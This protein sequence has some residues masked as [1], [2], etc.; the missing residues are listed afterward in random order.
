MI[1]NLI[2]DATPQN[3]TIHFMKSGELLFKGVSTLSNARKFYEPCLQWLHSFKEQKPLKVQ[4]TLELYYLNTSS[5]LVLVDILRVLN[6][7]KLEGTE[8]TIKW[9]YEEE[10]EDILSLGEDLAITTSSTFEY[11]IIDE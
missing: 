8:L 1:D 10:D 4:L 6:S 11:V 7:F 9:C 3:P 2:I 5:T